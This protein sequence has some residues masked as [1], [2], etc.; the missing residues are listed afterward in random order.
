[1]R[2]SG[3]NELIAIAVVILVTCF[4]PSLVSP[5]VRSHVGKAVALAATAWVSLHVSPHLALFLAVLVVSC[6]SKE[7]LEYLEMPKKGKKP[8]DE[9]KMPSPM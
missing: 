3:T 8:A 6:C 7:G 5:L 9:P 4:S 2:L 1:M